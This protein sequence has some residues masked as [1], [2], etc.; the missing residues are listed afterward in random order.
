MDA[1]SSAAAPAVP[2]PVSD[3]ALIGFACRA[4]EIELRAVQALAPRLDGAFAAACRVCL[5]CQGRVVVTGMGKSGHIAGKIAATLASTGTPAFFLHPAEAGHGDLGMITRTDAVLAL[6]NSG[7]TP[8]LVLLLPHLKRLGVPLIL[9]TGKPDSTLARAARVALDVS[10]PEEACPLNLAPT[11]STT[12]TLAMGDALAVAVLEA[13]G[14]TA[15][16]F[17]RSHPGGA[18]GRKLLLHVEDLMRTGTAVPRITPEAP[19]SAGLLEMSRKGLGMTVVVDRHERILGVFT[20]G[21]LRR[22]LDRQIDVH[23]TVMSAVMTSGAKSIGPRE[24]AAAAAHLMEVHRI[25]ALP[26]ADAHGKLI[27]ALNVHDL[28]RAGVV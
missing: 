9:M 13:R 25:T 17:A 4:L 8:E 6:S 2:T 16:D 24:L 28:M 18:L 26:V 5:A 19:L 14:F 1:P 23:N 10:V 27:G 7:E 12:A 20:D 21:D 15:Q 22:A 3:A 11:A